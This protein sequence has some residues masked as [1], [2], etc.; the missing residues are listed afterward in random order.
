MK[1]IRLRNYQGKGV[2]DITAK[3][4]SGVRR[5]AYVLSTGGGKTVIFCFIAKAISGLNKKVTIVVHRKKL[6]LQ[7]S[8]SL[9]NI[10]IKHRL[11][12]SQGVI[13]KTQDLQ[14]E[15][16][17]KSFLD[18]NSKVTVASVQTLAN[19][20]EEL[21]DCNML[22]IDECHHSIAS[23]WLNCIDAVPN[24]TILGVTATL[25]RLDGKPLGEVFDDFIEG[26]PMQELIDAGYLC[27]PRVF[28][29]KQQ[30][31]LSGVRRSGRDLNTGDL[32]IACDKPYLIGNAVQHYKF[33][34]DKVPAI[35]YCCT[36]AH[37]R[38]VDEEFRKAGYKSICL[39]SDESETEQF[40]IL[41]DLAEGKYHVVTSVDIISEGTD[42]PLVGCI[43][44]LRPTESLVLW[45]QMV[46]RPLRTYPDIP[47]MQEEHMR[48]LIDK[49]G[50]HTAFILDHA[51]NTHRHGLAIHGRTWSLNND[52]SFRKKKKS[53]T[54]KMSECPKCLNLHEPMQFCPE[55]G[56]KYEIVEKKFISAKTGELIELDITPGWAGG[57]SLEEAP[58]KIL[59][60]KAASLEQ[61][62]AIADARG[63]KYNWVLRQVRI[64]SDMARKFNH[65]ARI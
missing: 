1:K 30:I 27:R 15:L 42:V 51:G 19:K 50:K 36:K 43:I 64:R 31:D 11:I 56:H 28:A 55:C 45:D 4:M 54:V 17:G 52:I 26:P 21:A 37:A 39:T 47:L 3:L 53:E 6:V 13:K 40:K 57:E 16:Y 5:L 7:S 9:A 18:P 10:G 60:K 14:I 12:A 22:I 65:R 49:G 29:S 20:L 33:V 63:Y 59:L 35:V 48:K 24:A 44:C 25:A 2:K 23:Y 32:A 58:L 46:G 34:C 62:E 38:H 8:L 41:N 61:I